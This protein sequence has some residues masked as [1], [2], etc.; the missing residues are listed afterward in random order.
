MRKLNGR[1][2]K[3]A[4]KKATENLLKHKDEIN[5]LNV[6]PVPDGD[7]G[8][9]MVSTMMEGCKQLDE[10]KS[11]D[12]PDVLTAIKNG[13][14]MGARGNS[15]VILSQIFRGMAE[16]LPKGRKT[17]TPRDFLEMLRNARKVAYSAV[18]KPIEG[19]ILTVVRMID[20][21][22]RDL[23]FEDFENLM[24]WIL[25]ISEKAVELT[26]SLLSKLREAGVVD[27]GAKGLYYI[28]EGFKE[29]I[30]GAEEVRLEEIEEVSTEEIPRMVYEELEYRYCTEVI[31]NGK[32]NMMNLQTEI[33]D[34]L[35][36]V[37][38][39][40]VVVVQDNLLKV[41]VHTNHPGRVLERLLEYGDIMKVKIDNMK[42][43][44]E[45]IVSGV[46]ERKKVGV[47]AV[48]PGDG[49]AEILKSL[50]V[51][52]VIKGGQTMNPSTADLKNAINKIHAET[53]FLFPN[54]P[55]VFLAAKQAA[56]AIEDKE[57]IIIP[58]ITVQECVAAMVEYDPE[59][60]PE[61]LEKIFKKLAESCVPISITKAIRDSGKGKNKIRK[62]EYLVFV[63]KKLYSHG[64]DLTRVLD[65]VLQETSASSKEI[66]TLFLGKGA[67]DY[68]IDKIKKLVEEKYPNLDLETH[69]GGQPH[70]PYLIIL[71]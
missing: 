71:E 52:I 47:V 41:H 68:E 60:E 23:Q 34:F 50:G 70:Y 59:A 45:H 39:S 11:D 3:I 51:D 36:S 1:R 31:V 57:V 10:L 18:I 49:I 67:R 8:S 29:A 61:K 13:T 14:L 24:D 15:G 38:D 20:E 44:H 2:F 7:T 19:T 21:E 6:F 9:N 28:F 37:G 69:K 42:V 55:N 66:M 4:F 33:I 64:Y 40:T 17:I 48:S 54:N 53:V 35:N 30:L 22:S 63:R 27:A 58:T 26:P 43:Q 32:E 25:E 5:V 65:E 56:E 62:G 46:E 16:W 12:L